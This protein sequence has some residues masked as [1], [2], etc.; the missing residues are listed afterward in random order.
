MLRCSG[1]V[2]ME[3]AEGSA[4]AKADAAWLARGG[5]DGPYIIREEI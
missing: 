5:R 1:A 4:R 3:D 2:Y